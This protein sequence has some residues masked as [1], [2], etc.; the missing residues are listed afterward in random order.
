MFSCNKT[1]ITT[2]LH[3]DSSSTRPSAVSH[4]G[5][6]TEP[7]STENP[8]WSGAHQHRAQGAPFISLQSWQ[9]Y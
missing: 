6:D 2:V 9:D 8:R 5:S 1:N 3:F 4:T 7:E